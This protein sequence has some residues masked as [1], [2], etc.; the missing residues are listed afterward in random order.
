MEVIILAGGLGTRLRSVVSDVPKCMAPVGGKPFLW[1]LLE[2]LKRFDVERVIL[3]VGYLREVI[4][5]WIADHA[6]EYPFEF[7]FAVEEKP[8]GTG[9]GIRL[10]A[11]KAAGPELVV[12][13]G[14]TWFD[15]DL[16]QLVEFR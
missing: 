7:C 11:S 13:N 3:S 15:A 8:L 6:S 9:G 16:G 5:Q 14:D 4:E 10:A 2:G 1:Y 12:L